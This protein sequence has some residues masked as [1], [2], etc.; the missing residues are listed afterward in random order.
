MAME[1]LCD[2]FGI[3]KSRLYATYFEGHA[4]SGLEPDYETKEL[5]K[6]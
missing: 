1:L 3:D 5:W 2:T 4:S 6:Q